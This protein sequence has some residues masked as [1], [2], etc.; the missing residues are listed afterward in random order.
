MS[1]QRAIVHPDVPALL[2]GI[3]ARMATTIM[4][5]LAEQPVAHIVLTGGR[6]GIGGIGRPERAAA[7]GA[8]STS[9]AS[10]SGGAMS[11]SC[12]PVTRTATTRRPRNAMRGDGSRSRR[13][14]CIPCRPRAGLA[15]RLGGPRVRR[16][17]GGL[18]GSRAELLPAFDLVLLG[19]GPTA[20]SHRCSPITPPS[21][22]AGPRSWPSATPPKPPPERIS[23]ST[24]PSALPRRCGCWRPASKKVDAVR[25]AWL[26]QPDLQACPAI[27]GPRPTA[28]AAAVR[29]APR[30]RGWRAPTS[31]ES[32]ISTSRSRRSASS[33]SA[34]RA[35][36]SSS[37]ATLLH[38][39]QVRLVRLGLG[40]IRRVLLIASGRVAASR[41]VPGLGMAASAAKLGVGLMA[42]CAPEGDDDPGAASPRSDS[43]IGP[44]PILLPRM[45]LPPTTRPSCSNDDS[46]PS[47]ARNAQSLQARR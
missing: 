8:R 14:T 39:G 18:A 30:R 17:T 2:A 36:P 22:T 42:L 26:G 35:S 3:A 27:R 15:R 11:D 33:A 31:A 23:L 13:P 24:R 19:W 32:G 21:S 12:P 41:A 37:R 7:A 4:D 1:T 38:V 25:A 10:T 20:M 44:E 16:G 40:R 47:Y 34:S 45:A 28:D 43:P 6:N 46:A 29:Y 9:P 5:V